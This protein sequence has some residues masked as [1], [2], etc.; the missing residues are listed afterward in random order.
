MLTGGLGL[1][2]PLGNLPITLGG[3]GGIGSFTGALGSLNLNMNGINLP[4]NNLMIDIQNLP[5]GLTGPLA[6]LTQGL[7]FGQL[8]F[9]LSQ[10]GN[11]TNLANLPVTLNGQAFLL[12]QI[13]IDPRSFGN[14]AGGLTGP[15]NLSS[16]N[17]N[18]NSITSG[19]GNFPVDINALGSF[20]GINSL[21]SLP[22]SL[23]SF[24]N[25]GNITTGFGA[26]SLNFGGSAIQLGNLP[27]DLNGFGG[28]SFPGGAPTL[29]NLPVSI[30]GLGGMQN[31]GNLGNLS[32]VPITINGFATTVGA[33]PIK[34]SD[35][36]VDI[37]ATL[38]AHGVSH[39]TVGE[40]NS[41]TRGSC[42]VPGLSDALNN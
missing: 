32:N 12:G 27:L 16:L 3:L 20:T 31:I 41:C 39:L 22:V 11:I 29:G 38:Q 37:Q 35:L 6:G 18:L 17:F 2:G 40:L 7:T 4:F 21:G 9:D 5:G 42:S 19:L 10:L 25:L 26:L 24:G 33:L 15:L 23:G 8:Q 1:T 30:G 34:I 36:P 14:L 28:L 13:P